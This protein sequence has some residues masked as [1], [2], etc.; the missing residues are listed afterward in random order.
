M[1]LK[2]ALSFFCTQSVQY[3][4]QEPNE[5]RTKWT[6]IV[7]LSTDTSLTTLIPFKKFTSQE[8]LIHAVWGFLNTK[9]YTI[10]DFQLLDFII[11][12]LKSHMTC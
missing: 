12:E 3:L 2:I 11:K 10:G 4:I 6:I 1:V 8:T 5:P 9:T 7:N